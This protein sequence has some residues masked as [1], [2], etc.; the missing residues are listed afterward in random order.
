MKNQSIMYYMFYTDE[1]S[2]SFNILECIKI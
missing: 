1:L 2:V